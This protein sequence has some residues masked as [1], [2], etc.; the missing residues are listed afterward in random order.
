M[1]R[2]VVWKCVAK[3]AFRLAVWWRGLRGGAALEALA[4]WGHNWRRGG[5]ATWR[6][7]RCGF[8]GEGE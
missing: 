5:V 3:G 6:H 4:V 2:V 8:E 7:W 1:G